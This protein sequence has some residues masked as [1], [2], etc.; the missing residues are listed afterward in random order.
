MA[1][2]LVLAYFLCHLPVMACAPPDFLYDRMQ[3]EA[4]SL[5][6]LL[7]LALKSTNQI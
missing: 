4:S 6:W 5:A 2:D 7:F 3:T 1:F